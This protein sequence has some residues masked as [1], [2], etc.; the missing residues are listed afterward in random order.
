M[1]DQP[2]SY[3]NAGMRTT[4][5]ALIRNLSAH[6]ALEQEHIDATLAWIA[7]GAPLFRVAK[8][9]VPPQHLVSYFV[10]VDEAERKLLLVDHRNAGLWLPGGGHV[11]LDEHPATTVCRE[12][13]EELQ[14]LPTFLWPDPI[15]LTVTQTVGRTGGHTDVSFWYMLRGDTHQSLSFDT[16]EFYS[17]RWFDFDAPPLE[18]ADPH[19][20][21][22]M[23]K[24]GKRLSS[25]SG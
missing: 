9:A 25:E 5:A 13:A 8:P 10:L 19:M 20:G 17:V 24:L 18:R 6:D 7:S 2:I 4:I 15:F 21:R 11:E 12:L 23:A 14:I 3:D 22:F 1:G 16:G